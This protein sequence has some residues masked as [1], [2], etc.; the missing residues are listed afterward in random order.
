MK[1]TLLV[2]T[3]QRANRTW[4][5]R[6]LQILEAD[7]RRAGETNLLRLDMPAFPGI[8]VYLKDESTH[9]TG[10]L[11]HRLARSLFIYGLC[12]GWIGA[13]TRVI[14]SSSGS[15]AVSEAYFA[16]LLGLKFTAVVPRTTSPQK[17][18]AIR[19]YGGDCHFVDDPTTVYEVSATLAREC[20]GH[21]M[22]QFTFAERA[23]DWRRGNIAEAMFAQ[24]ANEEHP[25]PRWIVCSAGTGG[26]STTIG[27][28]IRYKSYATQLCLADPEASVF[29]QHCV[30]PKIT[31]TTGCSLIEGIG[32]PRVEPSFI[33]QEI[34]LVI[35]VCDCASIAAA[36]VLSRH[37]G[38]SCG[39]STGTN[40]W[41]VTRLV[42]EMHE[43]GEVGSIV[44]LLC[45]SGER[46]RSS[47]F[48]D[49]WIRDHGLDLA[50]FEKELETYFRAAA[51][52]ATR[53]R[54]AAE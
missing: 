42:Q 2:V 46:Y 24:M 43:A 36:R 41:A 53:E 1:R 27:R 52:P 28:H 51:A 33:P 14:E 25:V 16:Q 4:L 35:P 29:H 31:K 19:L 47:Y 10:S 11:K 15:T 32:R 8:A 45:D 18:E 39:G 13:G 9:P 34:D 26:T 30:D 23:T 22:D 21:Y 5:R 20:R 12:N 44:T 6:A 54:V 48:D 50:P 17:V 7:Q 38:K 3:L 37:L 40:F 49:A